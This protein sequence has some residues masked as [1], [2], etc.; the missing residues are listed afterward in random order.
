MDA[1]TCNVSFTDLSTFANAKTNGDT[2]ALNDRAARK[3]PNEY[4]AA[5]K[6][7]PAPVDY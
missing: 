2:S 3:Y 4:K 5:S 7:Y 6:Q 1:K